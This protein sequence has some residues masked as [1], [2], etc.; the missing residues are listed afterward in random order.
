MAESFASLVIEIA[1][2][3]AE[4]RNRQFKNDDL[5]IKI[6]QAWP[7]ALKA[8]LP[9][10]LTSRYK[11]DAS[12]G[13]GRWAEAPWLAVLHPAVTNTAMAGF[14]PVYLF[15]PGFKTVCLVL[16]QGAQ[17]LREAVG[18]PRSLVELERRAQLLQLYGGDWQAKG[19]HAGHFSTFKK[20]S[21]AME[22]DDD[23]DPWSVSVAF[24]VRYDLM[25]LPPTKELVA[26]LKR[27][28]GL[29]DRMAS[30]KELAFSSTD[31]ALLGLK[32]AGELPEGT[33]D[34]ARKVV[35]HKT[36]ETRLRSGKLI[37]DVKNRL[38]CVCQACGFSFEGTYG[39]HMKGFIEAHHKV[40]IST[41]PAEGALLKPTA[42][43]F[44]VLCS[45]CHRAIHA[46]GCPDLA[47]FIARSKF[48]SAASP[49]V[50]A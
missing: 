32:E 40:P 49:L 21:V 16:G 35:L 9:E 46:A 50:Q 30:R 11:F 8:E 13:K 24:G 29:Y 19:F 5:A 28:L 18:R 25:A 10:A 38:G 2:S 36:Y 26:D 4:A 17:R 12:P 34:G 33:T 6:R 45:N 39:E 14:Y 47:D 15:E 3:F 44:Y 37:R 48:G 27:M 22:D 20:V 43:D 42:E 7:K 1:E 41:L 23:A 31:S